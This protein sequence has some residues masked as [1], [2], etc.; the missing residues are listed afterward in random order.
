MPVIVAVDH[1]VAWG[2]GTETEVGPLVG[3][4]GLVGESEEATGVRHRIGLL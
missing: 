4:V 3:T 1:W 2:E